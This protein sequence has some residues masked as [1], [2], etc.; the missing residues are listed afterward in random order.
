M[1]KQH[2]P[3]YT[4]KRTKRK[5]HVM[6][7]CSYSDSY[8]NCILALDHVD[9]VLRTV[10]CFHDHCKVLYTRFEDLAWLT[11]RPNKRGDFLW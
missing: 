4:Q 8:N 1:M 7:M 11:V 2:G 3:I 5:G 6:H 10:L 9:P